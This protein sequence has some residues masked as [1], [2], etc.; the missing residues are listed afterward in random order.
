MKSMIHAIRIWWTGSAVIP[1]ASGRSFIIAANAVS[2]SMRGLTLTEMTVRPN[3]GAAACASSNCRTL[4]ALSGLK[5]KATRETVG[6]ASL[7]ICSRL[8]PTSGPTLV[9]PVVSSRSGEAWHEPGAYGITDRDHDDGNR[10]GSLLG[11]EACGRAEG[12][13]NVHLATNE[14][15]CGLGE[16]LRHS[17]AIRIVEGDVLAFD[18]TEIAHPV[19]EG[20]PVDRVV[21][22]ADARDFPRLLR[23]RHARPRG[24][25][26]AEGSQQFP[27]SDGDCHT[28]L[29]C[30]VRKGKDTT[31]RA[32]CPL[33]TRDPAERTPSTAERTLH[34]VSEP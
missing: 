6:I 5:R 9:L 20:V 15:R 21:D 16:S 26:A 17:I 8:V 1:N 4:E 29:P 30:E 3:V 25:R 18:V 7:R 10:G 11:R 2:N 27:P 28:P 19:T 24:H 22:Y 34:F 12:C 33:T 23:T 31:A 32:C 14:H 13:N